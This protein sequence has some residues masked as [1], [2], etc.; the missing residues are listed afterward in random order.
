MMITPPPVGAV[1]IPVASISI[2]RMRRTA[3]HAVNPGRKH[4]EVFPPRER[5]RKSTF[6]T[7]R[8]LDNFCLWLIRVELHPALITG[9][10]QAGHVPVC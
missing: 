8:F 2:Y 1:F 9:S 4:G 6:K 10:M 5:G 7:T 3:A